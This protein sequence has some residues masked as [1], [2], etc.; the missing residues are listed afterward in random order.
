MI[1][2]SYKTSALIMALS[3]YILGWAIP[4]S[5]HQ[6]RIVNTPK[7][8]V[9]D[10]EI[11]KAYYGTLTKEPHMF[12]INS[13]SDFDLYI[14]ILVP[15]IKGQKK[16]LT[17]NILRNGKL[18]AVLSPKADDWNKF[19]EIFGQSSYW[20]GPEYKKRVAAGEYTIRVQSNQYPIKYSLAIGETEAFDGKETLNAIS[21]IPNLKRN[22]FDES[23]ASFILS[24]L[25]GGYV[26][27]MY[28]SAFLM[29]YFVRFLKI[30]FSLKTNQAERKNIGTQ[31]RLLRLIICLG[32]LAL[33]ICTTWNPFILFLSGF[34]LFAT[35][36]GWCGFYGLLG[37]NTFVKGGQ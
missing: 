28:M 3:V 16:D 8:A 1:K 10:P 29:G 23:P 2:I 32:L 25:G 9:P 18:H 34:A 5:A 17:V 20:Q 13:D 19:F 4:A 26:I 24:P 15:D 6:P 14:N 27:V 11:S 30:K 21:L 37:K 35:L 7:I 33:A 36:I 31:D 12:S 22:F